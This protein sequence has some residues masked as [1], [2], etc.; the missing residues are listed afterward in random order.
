MIG[1]D[2]RGTSFIVTALVALALTGTVIA[3]ALYV[4]ILSAGGNATA[5]PTPR[6][7]TSFVIPTDTPTATL[8]PTAPASPT[9]TVQPTPGGTYIV[10]PG[11]FLSGIGEKFGIPWTLIAEA[12]NIAGP[13]YTIQVGQELIIPTLPEASDGSEVYVVKSGDSIIGI[14]EQFGIDPTDLADFNNLADWNSIHPGDLLYIPGPG[15]T[16]RPIES[17]AE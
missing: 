1:R 14:A 12:N 13:D 17:P 5:S 11:D 6:A 9:P 7:Q 8:E 15:W 4:G 16:P 10:Q 2:M 3:G